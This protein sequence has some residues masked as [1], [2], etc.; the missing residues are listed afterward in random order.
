MNRY[1]FKLCLLTLLIFTPFLAN[2]YSMANKD[3]ALYFRDGK[4]AVKVITKLLKEKKWSE[5]ARY[6]D[7]SG[8]DIKK[9]NLL[10][11]KFFYHSE[12]PEVGHPG[13]FNR[14][15]NPFAPG[16]VYDGEYKLKE[17]ILVIRVTIEIDQGDNMIQTGYDCFGMRKKVLGY[18]VIPGNFP[19]FP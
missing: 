17:N 7:L 4:E 12:A 1:I 8:T 14:Y 13:G 9:E 6:Y 19:I 10:S 3:T 18:Q 11:G 2:G 5:L 16:F 15:K